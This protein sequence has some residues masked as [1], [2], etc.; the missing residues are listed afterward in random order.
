MMLYTIF[1]LTAIDDNF[2]TEQLFFFHYSTFVT[3]NLI[4]ILFTSRFQME[5]L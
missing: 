1:R 3:W 4:L 2:Y 5:L